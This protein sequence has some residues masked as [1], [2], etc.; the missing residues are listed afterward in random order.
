MIGVDAEVEKETRGV[1]NE[2]DLVIQVSQPLHIFS[3]KSH[4][5]GLVTMSQSDW[6]YEMEKRA[7]LSSYP[8][9]WTV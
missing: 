1:A 9:F 7:G 3:S 4:I 6:K 2:G 5:D 8:T